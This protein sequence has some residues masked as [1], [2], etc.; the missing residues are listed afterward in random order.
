MRLSRNTEILVV[1]PAGESVGSE[2]FA[3]A[4]RIPE[5]GRQASYTVRLKQVP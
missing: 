3:I 5:L 2:L 1:N 4:V